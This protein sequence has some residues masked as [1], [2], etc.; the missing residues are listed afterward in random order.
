MCYF[1]SIDPELYR[2]K[3]SYLPKCFYSD[4][5]KIDFVLSFHKASDFDSHLFGKGS[6]IYSELA[7]F[8]ACFGS[9]ENF[10]VELAAASGNFLNE[11]IR[12]R[13]DS[14]EFIDFV[15]IQTDF[16]NSSYCFLEAGSVP[17]VLTSPQALLCLSAF[18]TVKINETEME[19]VKKM[20]EYQEASKELKL[21]IYKFSSSVVKN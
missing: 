19:K 5:Y 7:V 13:K 2:L 14:P 4:P 17:T 12:F 10:R 9:V 3:F 8:A 16:D 21:L 6:F 20:Q 15:T 11:I 1:L 18:E